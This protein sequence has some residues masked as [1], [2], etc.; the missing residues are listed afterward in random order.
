M[1]AATLYADLELTTSSKYFDK[2][3]GLSE[4]NFMTRISQST[5]LYV[6]NL[7]FTTWESQLM[8]LFSN[9]G[10][11]K[12]FYMGLDRITF[13]PCGFCF[14]EYNTREEALNAIQCL[15]L[16]LLDGKRIKVDFDYGFN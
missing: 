15:N 6:G 2:R 10:V 11:I 5:T 7:T 12:N 9:C 13:K 16:T 3:S 14:I 1:S 8:E 4:E